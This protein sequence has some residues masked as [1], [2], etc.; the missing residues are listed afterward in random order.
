MRQRATERALRGEGRQ[1]LPLRP[2]PRF[3]AP[4]TRHA[5]AWATV[6]TEAIT[7]LG[8]ALREPAGAHDQVAGFVM[9]LQGP[10]GTGG[11]GGGG[12]QG[13]GG[14]RRGSDGGRRARGGGRAAGG[15]QGPRGRQAAPRR[16]GGSLGRGGG[17]TG[18]GFDDLQAHQGLPSEAQDGLIL[19]TGQRFPVPP[20]PEER[21][22]VGAHDGRPSQI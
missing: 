12:L 3:P 10:G 14:P 20:L 11:D 9:L 1:R 5:G 18:G 7:F 6:G 22:A 17:G 15:G 21:E 4:E 2:A 19:G 13:G 16:G 8:A